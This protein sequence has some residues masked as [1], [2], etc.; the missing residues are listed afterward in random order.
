MRILLKCIFGFSSSAVLPMLLHFQQGPGW[1]DSV[2]SLNS[3]M[4]AYTSC[5][6]LGKTPPP[7]S[8]FLGSRSHWEGALILRVLIMR[9]SEKQWLCIPLL[10]LSHSPWSFG[11]WA[12]ARL[13][14][15]CLWLVDFSPLQAAI[16]SWGEPVFSHFLQNS[17]WYTDNGIQEKWNI[18]PL[19][20]R[21]SWVKNPRILSWSFWLLF[22]FA[23]QQWVPYA[24]PLAATKV[25]YLFT[26]Q[27]LSE[28]FLSESTS[29]DI[30]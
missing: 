11:Q 18:S 19:L 26:Q 14:L 5:G 15:C 28:C 10:T 29:V 25:I 30:R 21:N 1:W 9:Q 27:A 8:P 2:H 3:T 7:T 17:T 20:S 4:L 23:H 13:V 6:I 22:L 16:L 24:I 12:T